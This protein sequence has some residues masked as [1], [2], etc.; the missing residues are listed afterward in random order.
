MCYKG[1][2]HP[3]RAYARM[4]KMFSELQKKLKPS[5]IISGV[6]ITDVRFPTSLEAHGSDALHKDPD[7]S[8]AYVIM[9]VTG[10][11]HKG[12][13]LTFTLG[14][15]TEVVVAAIEALRPLVVGKSL[16]SVY[17]D[18]GTFWHKLV[19]E[20]QLRWIGPE[21]GVV[22]LATA[23]L[24]NALWDLWGKIEGKPVWK[25]LSDMTP[26]EIVSVIDF[27]H[28]TDVLTKD[29]AKE[30]LACN[31]STRGQREEEMRAKG[32]P[33]YI[34]S[35]GWL[36]YSEDRIRARCKDALAA[37]F[38]R[39]KMK[40][41]LDVEDDARRARVIREE[42]GWEY[43]LMTDAN[44]VRVCVYVYEYIIQTY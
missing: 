39:F 30:I 9:S 14:R 20:S 43:P 18:F 15:G 16:L 27:T 25:L 33:A 21:K 19:N 31:V 26:D 1:A 7:Y 23:A 12:H 8:A 41:G 36:G 32:F 4:F 13:G 11:E 35:V 17:T 24:I 10:L 37:G 40:V 6:T 44:Q 3:S 42:V 29:E 22:H 5:N 34:T 28:I 2:W 38:T